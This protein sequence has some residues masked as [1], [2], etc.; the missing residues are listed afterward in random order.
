MQGRRVI[1]F[2]L[3]AEDTMKE[4]DVLPGTELALTARSFRGRLPMMCTLAKARKHVL[5][6]GSS[7]LAYVVD[8]RETVANV[9]VVGEFPD[10][11]PDDLSDI[12]HERQVEFW[13]KLIPGVVSVAKTCTG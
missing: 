4:L 5:L 2:Q 7:Y 3:T 10:V 8:S 9:P 6:G 13:I 1:V 12:S 11:F